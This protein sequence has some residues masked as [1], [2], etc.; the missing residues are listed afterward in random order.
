M[1]ELFRA[2]TGEGRTMTA[3]EYLQQIR[4]ADRTIENSPLNALQI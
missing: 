3:K 1:A 4:K 2:E